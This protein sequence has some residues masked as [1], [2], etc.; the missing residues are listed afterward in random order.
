MKETSADR[1]LAGAR[2][3]NENVEAFRRGIARHLEM[4]Q[5]QQELFLRQAAE[6]AASAGTQARPSKSSRQTSRAKP[7]GA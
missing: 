1:F 2:R 6:E 7:T 4:K 3:F 5:R